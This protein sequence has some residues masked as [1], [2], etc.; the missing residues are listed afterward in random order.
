MNRFRDLAQELDLWL[1]IGGFQVIPPSH[2]SWEVSFSN[3]A[4]ADIDTLIHYETA[5]LRGGG[6]SNTTPTSAAH[7]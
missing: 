1:S 4:E 3:K 2:A 5:S 7:P 6:V